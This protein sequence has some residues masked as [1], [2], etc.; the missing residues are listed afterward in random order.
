VAILKGNVEILAADGS[1]VGR[2]MTY[3]HLPRG[4]E[5]AQHAGGT[6]SCTEWNASG[7]E[8]THVAMPD[9]RI[10]SIS[11]SAEAVSECSRNHILRY[12]TE[13]EP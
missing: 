5:R 4:Q 7:G 9:G 1:V 6:V 3:L 8:P 2:G 12:T 11:V 13:W 10:F